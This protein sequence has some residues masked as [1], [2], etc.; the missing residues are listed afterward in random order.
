MFPVTNVFSL[1]LKHVAGIH[2]IY[3]ITASLTIMSLVDRSPV[4]LTIDMAPAVEVFYNT[5]YVICYLINIV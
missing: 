5:V 1:I 2:S 3:P 4:P